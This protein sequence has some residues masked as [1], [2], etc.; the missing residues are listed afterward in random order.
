M[1][2]GSAR[3]IRGGIVEAA[4]REVVLEVGVGSER[5]ALEGHHE[6]GEVAGGVIDEGFGAELELPDHF[7]PA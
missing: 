5:I 4:E 1:H 3:Q 2:R 7:A 6:L